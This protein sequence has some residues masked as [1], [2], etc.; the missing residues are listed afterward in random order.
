MQE[1]EDKASDY[2]ATTYG[3]EQ[4]GE[5]NQDD[6]ALV[7]SHYDGAIHFS[8]KKGYSCILRSETEIMSIGEGVNEQAAWASAANRIREQLK[9]GK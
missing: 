2:F 3:A 1:S 7:L 6:V 9:Q 4:S 8:E 5:V